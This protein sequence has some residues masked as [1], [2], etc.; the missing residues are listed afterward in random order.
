MRAARDK[1]LRVTVTHAPS[2]HL[3]CPGS[4]NP[5]YLSTTN[6]HGDAARC[7]ESWGEKGR[8]CPHALLLSP[9]FCFGYP[10]RCWHLGGPEPLLGI[11]P[12]NAIEEG[13]K[14]LEAAVCPMASLCRLG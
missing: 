12:Q 2:P 11:K 7:Q 14:A 3:S 13:Q 9:H 10:H 8:K 1:H 6:F 4:Q 5:S